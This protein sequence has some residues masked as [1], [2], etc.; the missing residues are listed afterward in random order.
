MSVLPSEKTFDD[1]AVLLKNSG[2]KTKDICNSY[3]SQF[4]RHNTIMLLSF[5][6]EKSGQ[7][8]QTQTRLL[9]EE[10]SDQDLHCLLFHL[11]L[12]AVFLCCKANLFE[13]KGD[14]SNILGV[15]KFRPFMITYTMFCFLLI[16]ST[17]V[18]S[19][20]VHY[21]PVIHKY[22]KT[23]GRLF[24]IDDAISNVLLKF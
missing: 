14:Y 16:P 6:T 18:S 10:Q 3:Q 17:V 19:S 1:S 13:F 9:L 12:L 20:L 7:T 22:R 15:R 8:V 5:R 2:C 24:K 11:H 4:G 23:W 21:G